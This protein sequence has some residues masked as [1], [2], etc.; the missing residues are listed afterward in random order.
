[1]DLGFDAAGFVTVWQ[2]EIDKTARAVLARHWPNATRYEDVSKVN[3]AELAPVDVVSFG[4]PCQDLSVAGRQA[5]I[6]KGTRS[7]LFL[8]AVRII[9]EMREAQNGKGPR[10]IV[11]ENVPGALSSNGG[12]D[13][14]K[15]LREFRR[16]G[17]LDIAWRVLETSD[18]G[19]PQ[20]RRRV[21]VV[22]DLGGEG[23]GSVLS[24]APRV[25]WYPPTCGA[26]GTDI[27]GETSRGATRDLW[28]AAID[29]SSTLQTGGVAGTR[30]DAEAA[31]GGQL[32]FTKAA[33]AKSA[34]GVETWKEGGN[35]PTPNTFDNQSE[36]RATVIAV[37][38]Y[39]QRAY[40]N[41]LHPTLRTEADSGDCV[42]TPE[43]SDSYR[44]RRLTPRECERLQGWPDDHTRYRAD[45]TEISISAR[46][47]M[48]GNGVSAPVAQWVAENLARS[49]TPGTRRRYAVRSSPR[50]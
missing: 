43:S 47:R 7:G 15:A 3:G 41:G 27:A 10:F 33:R 22:V 1:M 18:F 32:V 42:V 34:E 11:W 49:L 14:A 36:S 26:S 37:D 5:G 50:R 13:F 19:P 17:A 48:I 46:Y 4:S 8:E 45:E 30:I 24:V 38:G 29:R 35:A 12:K 31:A 21:F 6:R 25:C 40:D 20:R 23:A 2:C 28:H 44:V 16:I 9:E 39:N